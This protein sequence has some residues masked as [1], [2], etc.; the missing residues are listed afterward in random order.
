MKFNVRTELLGA[1]AIE[2]KLE[3]DRDGIVEVLQRRITYTREKQFCDALIRLGWTPPKDC[4]AI[5]ERLV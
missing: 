5:K 2:T 1:G 3:I 4:T